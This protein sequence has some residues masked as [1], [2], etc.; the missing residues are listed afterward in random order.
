MHSRIVTAFILA[1]LLLTQTLPG[2]QPAVDSKDSIAV[3]HTTTRE[4]LLDLVVR[5]KHHHAV[6]DLKP[7]EITVYEDGVPQKITAF[8][9]IQG[10]DE[11]QT[12]IAAAQAQKQ[13]PSYTPNPVT[14][15]ANNSA[16]ASTGLNSMRQLN[17][18][19][20]VLA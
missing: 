6:T 7:E 12:E 13:S 2:Q 8:R 18:V 11:L 10:S 19:S 20:I 9:N 1:I 15:P 14:T 17:F 3:I 4:V 5:D 16:P